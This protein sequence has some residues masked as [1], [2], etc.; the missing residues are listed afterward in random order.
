MK[1]VLMGI[2]LMIVV[3]GIAWFVT[4]TQEIS[5]GEAFVSSNNSVRLSD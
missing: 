5:S 1:S 4:G 2:G 3:S